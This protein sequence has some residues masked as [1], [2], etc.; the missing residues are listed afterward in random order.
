MTAAD[1][2]RR[3]R[4]QEPM[5]GYWIVMDSPTSTERLARVGYDYLCLDQQHGLMGY[6]GLRNGLLATDAGARLGSV[7]TVGLVRAAANDLTWI[8][9][10]LDAGAFGIIVPLVDSAAD[11]AQAVANIKYPPLGR[12]SY[13][14]MRSQLRVG[15]VPAAAN[16]QTLVIVMIETPEGLANV[17]EI[18]ATPGVDALYVGPSDL[19]LA[20]GAAYPGDPDVAEVFDA[21]LERVKR[22]ASA[23]GISVGIHA[24]SGDVAAQRLAEGFL[25][26]SIASD[27]VHLEQA[28]A[29][30]LA[31]AKS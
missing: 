1:F 15:P 5:L 21:A 28:A 7:D 12:R 9:Q 14:P 30:H 11:A 29:A 22:A 3:F 27:V 8:G 20:V 10:A 2:A 25:F 18:A 24:P 13:G 16:E 31:A 26:S 6:E 23:A 17:E 4:A 19:A